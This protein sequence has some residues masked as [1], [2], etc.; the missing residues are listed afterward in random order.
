VKIRDATAVSVVSFIR[1]FVHSFIVK[2]TPNVHERFP[3]AVKNK[4]LHTNKN[5]KNT[6]SNFK[7]HNTLTMPKTKTE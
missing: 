6:K 4:D 3:K 1:P 5:N 2:H 7:T